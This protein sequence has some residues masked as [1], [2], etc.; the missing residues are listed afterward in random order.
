MKKGP[1]FQV[2]AKQLESN[3]PFPALKNE[4]PYTSSIA[5]VIPTYMGLSQN[6][7][8]RASAC[9]TGSSSD[10]LGRGLKPT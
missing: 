8:K 5:I 2:W 3:W 10:L 1:L 6:N 7:V 4:A 9:Q